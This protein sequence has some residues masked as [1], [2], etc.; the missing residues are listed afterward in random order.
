MSDAKNDKA[1]GGIAI[2]ASVATNNVGGDSG[3]SITADID[4]SSVT[5]A[6]PVTISATSTATINTLAIGASVAATRGQGFTAAVAAAGAGTYSTI[7]ET[8]E[9]SIKGGS[10]VSTLDGDVNLTATDDSSILA[11]SGGVSISVAYGK[12]TG[13]SLSGTIGAAFAGNTETSMVSAYIDSSTVNADG[14]VS[15][16]AQSALPAGSTAAYRIDALAFGVA[17]SGSG[18]NSTTNTGFAGALA[19]AGSGASNTI[20]N[21][22]AAYIN[23]CTNSDY[24]HAN[25]GA[26]SLTA[27]D[28][29]SVRADSGGYAIALAASKGGSGGQGAG[30]IGAS[31]SNNLIGQE[32]NGESVEA[33]IENSTVTAAGDVT[34]MATSTATID[35]LA[36]GGA[37]SGSGTGGTG[38][39]GQLVGAA[40]GRSTRSRRRSR[41]R[42]RAAARSRPPIPGAST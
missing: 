16:T 3:E 23:N 33:Y 29:T 30:A 7:D 31:E 22:I 24:V 39:S 17:A 26:L 19:G 35:A 10:T 21:A 18:S 20:D 36:I 1:A 2:G 11:D 25:D 28:A 8:I 9:A 6:G 34:I 40:R 41:P 27:S 38:L 15:L 14:S 5:S 4:N 37:G 42:S 32:G 13:K 12:G